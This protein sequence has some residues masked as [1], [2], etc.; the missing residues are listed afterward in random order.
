MSRSTATTRDLAKFLVV[1]ETAGNETLG[2]QIPATFHAYEK[3]RP[4][5]TTVVGVGGFRSLSC[6]ALALAGASVPSLRGVHVKADGSLEELEEFHAQVTPAEFFEGE[7]V[8]LDRLLG[9]L[10]L[11]IGEDLTVRLVR[12]VWPEVPVRRLDFANGVKQNEKTQ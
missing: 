9:L 12:E 8:L 4:Q 2:T 5:L 3:L 10:T 7:V 11:F 1:Y 6:R